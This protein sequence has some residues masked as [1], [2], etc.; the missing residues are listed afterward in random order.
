MMDI[1]VIFYPITKGKIVYVHVK[2]RLI[3]DSGD[4]HCFCSYDS[5]EL[6]KP[7][8][9]HKTYGGNEKICD[10]YTFEI[11]GPYLY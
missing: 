6:E 8:R 11:Y 1:A 5:P 3:Y 2:N 9:R 4:S 10:C 7:L